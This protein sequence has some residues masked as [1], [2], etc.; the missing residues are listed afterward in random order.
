MGGGSSSP[1]AEE[2][3][4]DNKKASIATTPDILMP[5]CDDKDNVD[6]FAK[7]MYQ[8]SPKIEALQHILS[9]ESGRE[10]FMRFLRTEYAAENLDF[11]LVSQCSFCVQ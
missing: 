9:E 5:Y 7:E 2:S 4:A 10:A 6:I 1:R 8:C 3:S 11:F